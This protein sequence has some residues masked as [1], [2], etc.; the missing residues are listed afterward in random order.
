M[1]GALGDLGWPLV[2]GASATLLG[3][4]V[5]GTINSFIVRTVFKTIMLV[6]TLGVLHALVFLPV[7]MSLV[8]QGILC[9]KKCRRKGNSVQNIEHNLQNNHKSKPKP[10]T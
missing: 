9:I 1:I 3:V 5:L 8:H 2:Q 4:G 6:I 10:M 7:T